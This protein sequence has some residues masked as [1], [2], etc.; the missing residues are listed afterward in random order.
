[1]AGRRKQPPEGG[2]LVERVPPHDLAAEVAVLGACLQE[3]EALITVA[4]ILKPEHFFK[5]AHRRIF[6]ACLS[7][8]QRGEAV[9]LITLSNALHHQG[10]LDQVGGAA[11][12]TSLVDAV[13][14]AANVRYHAKIVKEKALLREIIRQ[15]QVILE[16]AY[17]DGYTAIQE[18]LTFAREFTTPT[19]AQVA[20]PTVRIEP[21]RAFLEREVVVLPD[22]IAPGILGPETLALLHGLPKI[23]K[24]LFALQMGL[25]LAGMAPAEG[26]PFFL[27]P[28]FPIG[29][30]ERVL[31]VN[32]E[33]PEHKLQERLRKM[34]E[35]AKGYGLDVELALDNFVPVTAKGLLRLDQPAGLSLLR[36]WAEEAKATVLIL[37]PLG[38]AHGLEEN[39]ARE[40]G[41]LLYELMTLS[42]QQGLTLILVHHWGKGHQDQDGIHRGRGSSVFADRPDTVLTL[43]RMPGPGEG[44][45]LKLS[46]TL[47]NGEP[48]EPLKLVRPPG[49]LLVQV[50]SREAEE[51]VALAWLKQLLQEEGEI[52]TKD[53]LARFLEEGVGSRMAFYRTLKEART[54]GWLMQQDGKRGKPGILQWGAPDS[55]HGP[56]SSQGGNMN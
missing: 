24:S 14:T 36:R 23:G 11:Y 17:Q 27:D 16:S 13:P 32:L 29:S 45:Y 54:E 42:R 26:P 10:A 25:C 9:D 56:N 19:V 41:Q 12:L 53:A 15:A 7:L 35:E 22:L 47:R 20:G 39:S 33:I 30:P 55:Y 8:L 18:F 46:F 40:M 37:D 43:E 1:M 49:S 44:V 48:L 2:K 4:E 3:H 6:A 52:A 51:R 5:E 38:A 50:V 28:R 21:L 34:L 31:Y